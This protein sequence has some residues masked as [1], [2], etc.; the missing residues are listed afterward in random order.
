MSKI[1]ILDGGTSMELSRLGATY[2]KDDPLW[3]AR[4]LLTKPEAFI[5]CHKNFIEA[6]A[7]VVV[8]G[9]YQASIEGFVK[10]AGVT[11]EQAYSLIKKSVELAQ[12]AAQEANKITGYTAEV[13]GS[14]GAYGAILHDG[15]EYTGNYVDHM[16]PQELKDCHRPR[17]Q[18]LVEAKPDYVAIET[19]PSITEAKAIVDLLK[20]EFPGVK[21]WV[22]YTC[23]DETHI[24]NGETFCDAVTA[25]ISSDNVVAVGI[26]CT[27]PVLISPLLTSIQHLQL[28][29]PILIKPN[30][31]ENWSVEEGWYGRQESSPLVQTMIKEW[32]DLG[33]RWI[34]GCCQIF[35]P[36]IAEMVKVIKSYRKEND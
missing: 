14:V 19:I 21:A 26:N 20:D 2:I 23:K 4:I 35:P 33:A 32:I 31:G 5:Q 1:K 18:A 13:A 25:V 9:S 10:H 24:G 28:D 6:G 12:Q 7:E 3:S 36:D 11:E 30:S 22:S 8:T 15:S 17:L 29:K 16:T 34:G 27:S